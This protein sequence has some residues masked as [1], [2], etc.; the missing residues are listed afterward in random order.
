[1]PLRGARVRLAGTSTASPGDV[2]GW[3]VGAGTD[4]EAHM[5]TVA[6]RGSWEGTLRRS[7]WPAACHVHRPRKDATTGTPV[8][9][10]W[11]RSAGVNSD[12]QMTMDELRKARAVLICGGTRDQ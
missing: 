4:D 9:D 3:R 6:W 7:T 1:M 12:E 11:T 10:P 8:R 5:V 2:A